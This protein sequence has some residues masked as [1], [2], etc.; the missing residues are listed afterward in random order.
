MS[1]HGGVQQGTAWQ[2]VQIAWH[3]MSHHGGVQQGMAWRNGFS[4]TAMCSMRHGMAWHG[5]AW[6]T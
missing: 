4:R 6:K 1:Q 2:E 3:G 5:V